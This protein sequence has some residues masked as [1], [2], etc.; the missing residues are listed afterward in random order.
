MSDGIQ[1]IED[2]ASAGLLRDLALF[3][4]VANA[5]IASAESLGFGFPADSLY[6]MYRA[7]DYLAASHGVTSYEGETV[8]DVDRAGLLDAA[9]AMLCLAYVHAS[10]LI[11]DYYTQGYD[12]LRRRLVAADTSAYEGSQSGPFAEL[13]DANEGYD[14]SLRRFQDAV[15]VR[16]DSSFEDQFNMLL[17]EGVESRK[18]LIS[19]ADGWVGACKRRYA[20]LCAAV[21]LMEVE[22]SRS[23]AVAERAEQVVDAIDGVLMVA[24]VANIVSS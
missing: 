15:L 23:D 14:E 10:A 5:K 24:D 20:A 2:S 12:A 22:I 16:F 13:A 8:S 3:A 4:I 7:F 11:G 21:P 17:D 1:G 9:H 18:R 6:A 19:L